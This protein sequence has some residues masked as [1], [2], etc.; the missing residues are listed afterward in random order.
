MPS[1]WLNN[2]KVNFSFVEVNENQYLVCTSIVGSFS[3]KYIEDIKTGKRALPTSE[4]KLSVENTDDLV[5]QLIS[6]M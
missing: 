3:V 5:N 4:Q 2:N 6:Q 1:P